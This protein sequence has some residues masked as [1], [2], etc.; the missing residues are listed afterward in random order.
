MDNWT[1]S[2]CEE[3]NNLLAYNR[4]ILVQQRQEGLRTHANL[5]NLMQSP[6]QNP[7]QH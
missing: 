4:F 2:Y 1:E 3:Q 7:S 5:A 6:S